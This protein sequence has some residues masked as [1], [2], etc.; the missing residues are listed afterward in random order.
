MECSEMKVAP[1]PE[2]PRGIGK[3]ICWK[4]ILI[5]LQG[6]STVQM[7]WWHCQAY[8]C[9]SLLVAPERDVS[10]GVAA[11]T[12][13]P[14]GG[15]WRRLHEQPFREAGIVQ[16]QVHVPEPVGL[17][18]AAVQRR[19]LT[20][21][22]R[23]ALNRRRRLRRRGG[24]RRAR[25]R[26][27][28]GYRPEAASLELRD[29]LERGPAGAVQAARERGRGRHGEQPR[30]VGEVEAGR[31]AAQGEH[32]GV[33]RARRRLGGEVGAEP[34]PRA[35][36]P[37][38]AHLAHPPARGAPPP[39]AAEHRVPRLPELGAPRGALL[40][41]LR[42]GR[43]PGQL[44]LLGRGRGRRRG[45]GRGGR[46]LELELELEPAHV[47]GCRCSLLVVWWLLA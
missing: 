45:G 27:V 41:R 40:G 24:R 38:D 11:V 44:V 33:V 5:L 21:L 16:V 22:H 12:M 23:H 25:G 4:S 15:R 10:S 35:A 31:A 8:C 13:I 42:G 36:P 34:Q 30:G 46:V 43:G 2:S 29:G 37:G 19:R 32:R 28:G 26:F 7:S 1:V 47:H 39:H 17:E 3:L 20:G 18:H 14:G 9:Y 6:T